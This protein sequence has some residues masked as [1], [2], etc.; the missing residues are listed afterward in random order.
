MMVFHKD[1]HSSSETEHEVKSGF[2]LDV[3]ISKS[4][5]VLELFFGKYKPL[6]IGGNTLLVLN[7][8]LHIINSIG[9]LNF[10]RDG[11]AGQGFDEDLHSSSET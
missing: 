11:L 3:V 5:S 6:L 9:V 4:A 10:E 2:L 8:G 1:L 7:F